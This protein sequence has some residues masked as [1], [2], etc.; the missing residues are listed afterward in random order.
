MSQGMSIRLQEQILQAVDEQYLCA[1]EDNLV[2]YTKVT[3]LE[4]VGNYGFSV[5]LE[6]WMW[7]WCGLS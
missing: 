2:G 3:H 5:L 7:I 4:K 6:H 1:L